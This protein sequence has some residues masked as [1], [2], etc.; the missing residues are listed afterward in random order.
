MKKKTGKIMQKRLKLFKKK[1]RNTIYL[2]LTQH[3]TQMNMGGAL[4][5]EALCSSVC[6]EMYDEVKVQKR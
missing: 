5:S 6:T 2:Y 3:K 1:T 4:I